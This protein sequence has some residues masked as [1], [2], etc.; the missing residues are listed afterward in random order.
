MTRS[1]SP[2]V[3][4]RHGII[5]LVPKRSR[6]KAWVLLVLILLLAVVGSVSYLG[7]RQTVPGVRP[8]STPPRFLGQKTPFKLVLEARRGNVTRV[9][10]RVVQSGTPDGGDQAGGALGR[11]VEIPL[12]VESGGAPAPRGQRHPRGVGARRLLAAA[13]GARTA[14]SPATRSPSTSRRRRSSCSPP[15]RYLSPGGTGL[16]AFRVTG[17]ARTDV[18]AGPLVF[19]SFA[20]GPED[21]GARVALIALPW[22]FDAGSGAG[23]PLDRRRPATP[24]RAAFRPRSSR[25]SSPRHDR[26]QGRVP[27]GARSRSSCPSARRAS[28]SSTAS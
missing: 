11:R 2:A 18:S 21:R 26:D 19:P 3:V 14:R 15:R 25:A 6:A 20:Y 13:G 5:R 9:E 22:D 17:A 24:R 7:W 10:V 12:V 4:A 1:P 27:P 23:D 16:V 28:R 8:S